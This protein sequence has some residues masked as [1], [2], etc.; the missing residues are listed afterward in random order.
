MRDAKCRFSPLRT[1][2]LAALPALCALTPEAQATTFT[3]NDSTDYPAHVAPNAANCAPASA[4]PCKLRDA[5][6]AATSDENPGDDIVFS[7]ATGSTTI[8]LS[9]SLYVFP[10]FD[11][12]I[13]IDGANAAGGG[14][15]TVNGNHVAPVFSVNRPTDSLL[16]SMTIRNLDIQNGLN[17]CASCTTDN[18]GGIRNYGHLMLDSV[19]VSGNVAEQFGGGIF[20]GGAGTL[21]VVN[22]TVSGNSGLRGGGIANKAN[23]SVINSTISGNSERGRGALYNNSQGSA[24]VT[25]S[26]ITGN[27]SSL[28]AFTA[29]YNLGTV[30]FTNTVIGDACGGLE[31]AS[32]W[33]DGGGNLDSATTCGFSAANS[34]SNATLNLGPLADNGGPTQTIMPGAGSD[35]INFTVCTNAPFADQRDYLRPDP[36]SVGL[37]APCD[38][39]AVEAGSV[40]SDRVFANGFGAPPIYQ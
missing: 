24:V 37:A 5:I 8:V 18:G 35:A 14:R 30:T 32:H 1:A 10:N 2:F 11:T 3:V 40:P 28:D 39:G 22:S 29:F 19:T 31:D 26:T 21:T 27:T 16:A 4:T 13:T 7:L 25:N 34:K 12:P 38:S 36:A 9:S 20:N 23:L 33:T 17:A 15:V 6:A